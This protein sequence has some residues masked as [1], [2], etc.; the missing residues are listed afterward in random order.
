M[1][2]IKISQKNFK[3]IL[4]KGY[5]LSETNCKSNIYYEKLLK[6]IISE[7]SKSEGAFFSHSS[8]V[9]AEMF[10]AKD[11][12]AELFIS[13]DE[14]IT[15]R[16]STYIFQTCDCDVLFSLC[17]RLYNAKLLPLSSEL[18]LQD[19]NYYLLLYYESES[20][21]TKAVISEYGNVTDATFLS[22]L[23][24]S[25]HAKLICPS[26]AVFSFASYVKKASD[27]PL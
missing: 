13:F 21:V 2:I 23:R 3:V 7:I 25:E 9:C 27:T 22:L 15:Y 18:Y 14:N 16:K 4:S 17:Y 19:E 10:D 11:G 24:L 20:M 8:K 6:S 26:G 12:S 1:Q 5:L